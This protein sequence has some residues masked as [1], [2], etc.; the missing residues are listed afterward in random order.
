MQIA[1]GVL[2]EEPTASAALP[3]GAGDLRDEPADLVARL[4][5]LDRGVAA[6]FDQ[7][8]KGI[9]K[10]VPLLVGDDVGLVRKIVRPVV[11]DLA[12][13]ALN[14]HGSDVGGSPFTNIDMLGEKTPGRQD[15]DGLS[16]KT[17]MKE[18]GGFIPRSLIRW[19]C[20]A[21]PIPPFGGAES[22]GT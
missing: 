19:R 7:P 4:V 12:A 11:H 1:V 18:L 20:P 8:I 22:D 2:N 15:W 5:A 9:E 6:G 13:V 17:S 16:G 10:R 14:F 3:G 21:L